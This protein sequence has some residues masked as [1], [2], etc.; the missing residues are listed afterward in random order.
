[1]IFI[2]DSVM[3]Q[4]KDLIGNHLPERGGAL[5][6]EPGKPIITKFIFDSNAFTTSSMYCPSRKLNKKVKEVEDKE[7]LEYKGIIH[8]HPNQYD[9]PSSQDL[10]ELAT[11]LRLNQHMPYY[12][13][14]IVTT[15]KN[16]VLE[17]HELAIAEMKVSFYAGFPTDN[18]GVT[19]RKME[20]KQIPEA[21]LT[22]DLITLSE[23]KK[24]LHNPEV[25]I[26]ASDSEP[27]LTGKIEVEDQFEL[28]FLVDLTY[29]Y[30]CPRMLLTYMNGNQEEI[31]PLWDSEIPFMQ[32]LERFITEKIEP[33]ALNSIQINIAGK[34]YIEKRFLPKPKGKS[35]RKGLKLRLSKERKFVMEEK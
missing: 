20:V 15:T 26:V 6:G 22:K 7:G 30:T 14:P 3:G 2:L 10:V 25:F 31:E 32:L 21:Q 27:M 29:P 4:I 18:V 33:T 23:K 17:S 28:L 11:G 16:P 34:D 19:L 12:L 5:L 8:S 35:L 24:G 1:M 9:E 13:V